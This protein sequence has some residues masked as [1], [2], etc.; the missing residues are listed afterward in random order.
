MTFSRDGSYFTRPLVL[1]AP[2]RR[3]G[4]VRRATAG[5]SAVWGRAPPP[6]SR[7]MPWARRRSSASPPRTACSCRPPGSCLPAFDR[8]QK[9]SGGHLRL[10]WAGRALGTRH[11]SPPPGRLLPGSGGD[12]RAGGRPS[13][14]GPFRQ[15]GHGGHA[16][17]PGKMGDR[18]LCQRRRLAADAALR[19]RLAH[20]H[21]RR[22]LWRLRRR[23]G[24]GL[25]ARSLLLRHRRIFGDRLVALRLGLHREVHGPARRRT[26]R[27][28][29]RPRCSPMPRPTAAGC[30]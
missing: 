3:H 22:Q 8:R 27:A 26:P 11:L 1:P 30:A 21:H 29:T 16:P 25:G 19:R 14:L 2:A 9:I 23:P 12:H 5:S 20:R 10:R 13:R 7:S 24:R 18:R 28:I 6:L 15:E 17:L 4:A